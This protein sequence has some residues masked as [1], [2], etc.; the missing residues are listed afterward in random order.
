MK[1][2]I[3]PNQVKGLIWKMTWVS[4]LIFPLGWMLLYWI[5]QAGIHGIEIVLTSLSLYF[6]TIVLLIFFY[7]AVHFNFPQSRLIGALLV[8]KFLNLL[9]ILLLLIQQLHFSLFD[10]GMGFSLYFISY[11][12][13]FSL[14]YFSFLKAEQ[15]IQKL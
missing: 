12:L 15:E 3:K 8:L 1:P 14:H 2:Q 10:I 6:L 4:A 7:I 5:H 11:T 13:A 9:V